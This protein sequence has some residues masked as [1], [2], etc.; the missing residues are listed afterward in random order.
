MAD[1]K[2][3]KRNKTDTKLTIPIPDDL[4]DDVKKVL[5]DQV[6]EFIKER[7]MNG[8]NVYGRK[9]KGKAGKYTEQHAEKKG[10]SRPVDLEETGAMLS[11]LTYFK[12]KSKGDQITIGFRKGTKQERK[13]EGNILGSYGRPARIYPK[14]RPFLD[15]TRKDFN[16]IYMKLLADAE[17]L[18]EELEKEL[19]K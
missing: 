16:K 9:W 18:E 7:T 5:A 19:E 12:G 13:A 17:E 10:Y 1:Q 3:W 8:D 2:K 4:P 15:I 14:A 6:I 11:A